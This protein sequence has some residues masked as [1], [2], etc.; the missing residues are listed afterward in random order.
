MR[1]SRKRM[2]TKLCVILCSFTMSRGHAAITQTH[3][4]EAMRDSGSQV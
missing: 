1:L 3:A 4:N 2:P